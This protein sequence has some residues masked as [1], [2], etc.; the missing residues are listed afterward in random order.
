M[1]G[2]R[3]KHTDDIVAFDTYDFAE[4]PPEG[5]AVLVARDDR[6]VSRANEADVENS[7]AL[8][9]PLFAAREDLFE[10]EGEGRPGGLGRRR[11]V[12]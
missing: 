7:T 5:S 11:K 10:C 2:I 3:T 4:T 1:F 6:C 12:V 8:Q 9:V